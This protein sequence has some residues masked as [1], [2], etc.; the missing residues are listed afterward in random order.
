M[1]PRRCPSYGPGW[2]TPWGHQTHPH[3]LVILSTSITKPSPHH[4][5][6]FRS[7]GPILTS[8]AVLRT[9]QYADYQNRSHWPWQFNRRSA[10]THMCNMASIASITVNC[11][12]SECCTEK[13]YLTSTT[14]ISH[15]HSFRETLRSFLPHSDLLNLP[16]FFAIFRPTSSLKIVLSPLPDSPREHM[17]CRTISLMSQRPTLFHIT[18]P[19]SNSLRVG[20]PD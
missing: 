19:F 1:A 12:C 8:L 2:G 6:I 10:S 20:P 7:Y 11:L 14:P 5:N 9:Y 17:I 18:F 4:H 3:W 13:T 16:T 15:H